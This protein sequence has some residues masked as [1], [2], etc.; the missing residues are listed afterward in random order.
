MLRGEK[1]KTGETATPQKK[2]LVHPI[3]IFAAIMGCGNSKEEI[4]KEVE[5]S[6]PPV[7]AE[8][9]SKPIKVEDSEISFK[10]VHSAIRWNK[11]TA[12]V[13]ALI[14]T[15]EDA[16]IRD[17]GNGNCPLHI[18]AQNGHFN[19]V[20]LLLEKGANVNCL[21]NK[22]NTPL[23]MSLSYDYIEVSEYLMSNGADVNI[24]NSSAQPARKGIDGDKCLAA[25][26]LGE[27]AST[28]DLLAAF[29]KCNDSVADLDKASF[30]GLGLRQKKSLGADVWTAEVQ[31]QFKGVMLKL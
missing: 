9:I 18:A 15:K 29:Q 20:K 24:E 1:K 7:L 11:S 19:L 4:T 23:H 2:M 25:V 13:D 30:A 3:F 14:K 5:A 26:Y 22:S 31:E 21:N 10:T 17:T 28:E 6:T 27:A 8:D 16:N 12:D